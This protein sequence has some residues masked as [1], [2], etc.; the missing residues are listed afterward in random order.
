MPTRDQAE[1]NADSLLRTSLAMQ[2]VRAEVIARKAAS[3]KKWRL[4]C[5][6]VCVAVGAL[7]GYYVGAPVAAFSFA[8]AGFG[9]LLGE[10]VGAV[11]A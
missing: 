11:T 4:V 1:L 6:S 7:V 9:I 8:G 10:F 5:G 2:S 3:R